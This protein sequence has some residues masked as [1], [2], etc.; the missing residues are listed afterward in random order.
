MRDYEQFKRIGIEDDRSYYIPFDVKDD[1]KYKYGIID[2]TSSSRFISLDGLWQI[3]EHNSPDNIDINE[4]LEKEIIVPSCVQMHGF[5]HIQYLNTRYPFIVN[6]P[7]V[8]HNNPCW[9]YRRNIYINKQDNEKY[10]INFEG[11]DNAFY[12]Y[13]N[14]VKKGYSQISHSTSEFDITDLLF[15]GD[16]TIDVVVLKWSA[17]TYLE[18]Q[19]K[20]RFSGIFR[21]VYILKRPKKHITDYFIKVNIINNKGILTFIND[22][23]VEIDL[24]IS[25]KSY[26]IKPKSTNKIEINNVKLWSEEKPYLYKLVLISNDEKIIEN[27]GFRVVK[28]ENSVFMIN[29]TPIKLKGVNRHEFSPKT[30]CAITLKDMYNDIKL[31]KSLN[32]NAVRCSHYPN[33]PEFYLLCD[34]YGVYVMDEADIETHGACVRNGGYDL[35]LWQEFAENELFIEG[36]FDRHKSLV[37]RDKNRPSVIIWS[38]GNEASFGKSF[39]NGAKYIKNR[40]NTRPI[41]YEGLQNA[42]KK[43]YYTK[44]VDMAS[45]MYPSIEKIKND[46]L[47]NPNETRPFILCEYS[48]AMGNSCGDL[49]SYWEL[50]YNNHQMMGGFIWE[51]ADHAIKTKNRYLYGGDFNEEIHDGNFCVDGL[52]TPDRKVKSA[53]L[54]M[55]AIYGGKLESIINDVTIP[56]EYNNDN[57]SITYDDNVIKI[58]VNG[59]SVF[60]SSININYLRYIDND[61]FFINDWLEK[62]RLANA[63][64]YIYYKEKLDNGYLFKGYIGA[65]SLEPAINYE[66]IYKI[67]NN[68]LIID[69]SYIVADYI[70]RLPRFGIEF[71]ID[72]KYNKFSY[73]GYGPYESYIDKHI[74]SDYDC[75][76]SNAYDNYSHYIYPQESG[77]HYNTKYLCVNDLFELTSDKPYSFSINPYT[78]KQILDAKHDFEL[79]K[80]EFVNVCIDLA[81]R[82]IG[83]NSCGPELENDYEIPKSYKNIFIFKF[84]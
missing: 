6:P 33:C 68:S 21:S 11:V 53:A 28:I 45:M 54:E 36:I 61:R 31:M 37:E 20:F 2:R 65:D 67:E 42:D 46:V 72:N 44:L 25:N 9:H 63:K 69:L 18:C 47:N 84:K 55:Q 70:K 64:E 26:N 77:S 75:Y 4:F 16:N 39:F 19:D 40:D 5:D 79:K 7:Y 27:I 82:G 78:T 81:M 58:L 10:Y 62:Y 66:I 56:K 48:H 60:K 30:A 23:N 43:Y 74:A 14:G 80:N 52:V 49:K 76:S 8:P 57:I 1:I 34:K 3:S 71:Q 12:L 24:K 38:L 13:I 32:I 35:K 83:S 17:S 50:I 41:H 15:N 29:N 51:W 22:S 59:N 73:I